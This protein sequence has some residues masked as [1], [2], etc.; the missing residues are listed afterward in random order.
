V[1][2]YASHL[3]L[4]L[5]KTLRRA[6]LADVCFVE[7]AQRLL[8]QSGRPPSEVEQASA[9][10]EQVAQL[11]RQAVRRQQRA[12]GAFKLFLAGLFK[13]ELPHGCRT[14]LVDG[15]QT[16][17]LNLVDLV[18]FWRPD[19]ANPDEYCRLTLLP[20]LGQGPRCVGTP[21]HASP[22]C[23]QS[24]DDGGNATYYVNGAALQHCLGVLL[25]QL[26]GPLAKA[27]QLGIETLTRVLAGDQRLHALLDDQRD[28]TDDLVREFLL[29]EQGAAEERAA[30]AAHGFV[31]QVC[32][33][34]EQ[35]SALVQSRPAGAA[36]AEDQRLVML[37]SA[38]Q[39]IL[40]QQQNLADGQQTLA[41]GQQQLAVQQEAHRQQVLAS[42]QLLEVQLQ[43]LADGQQQ[44]AVQQEAHKQHVLARQ[45]EQ[46]ARHQALVVEQQELRREVHSVRQGEAVLELA[47]GCDYDSDFA[48]LALLIAG[49]GAERLLQTLGHVPLSS[50]L[51]TQLQSDSKLASRAHELA[52]R[53]LSHFACKAKKALLRRC[54]KYTRRPW[55][56]RVVSAWRPGYFKEDQ[57]MLKR[58]FRAKSFKAY[59]TALARRPARKRAASSGLR[60]PRRVPG[61]T[62]A[63]QATREAR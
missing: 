16:V 14:L 45:Q 13:R 58:L 26:P 3:L 1:K 55:G 46:A 7:V 32:D 43:N 8:R 34:G 20:A 23:L 60:A 9:D 57:E 63:L 40:S 52:R 31:A 44:L 12:A 21:D 27:A 5:P 53:A 62:S 49:P 36:T 50:F 35:S 18:R 61:A 22:R 11:C 2:L 59:L 4:A 25:G 56:V 42:Q 51:R 17:L 37:H 54:A 28:V 24:L 47:R 6:A 41:N 19:L 29:G 39:K 38:M 48:A 15:Q 30:A 33:D 10:L